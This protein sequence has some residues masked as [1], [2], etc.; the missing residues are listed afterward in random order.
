VANRPEGRNLQSVNTGRR[1]SQRVA[2]DSKAKA[3]VFL[4]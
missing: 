2:P 1:Y 3:T 4:K